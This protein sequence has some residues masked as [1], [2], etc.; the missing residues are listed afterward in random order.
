M[1]G[2][3]V[4]PVFCVLLLRSNVASL[5]SRV[6]VSM[7]RGSYDRSVVW[8]GKLVR[9]RIIQWLGVIL[10]DIRRNSRRREGLCG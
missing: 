5:Y 8:F 3:R 9:M 6:V 4:I 2:K 7:R 1:V 10:V